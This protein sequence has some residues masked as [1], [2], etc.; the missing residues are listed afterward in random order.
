M[1]SNNTSIKHWSSEDQPRERMLAKGASV[2]SDTE[3]LTILIG[4]GSKEFSA[5]DLARKILD[6]VQG[7]WDDLG[8]LKP[9][10]LIK[11]IK[12][13]G[14]AKAITI[15]TALEIGRRRQLS[16][17]TEKT[18]LNNASIIATILQNKIGDRTE[19]A[20][21]VF[22]LRANNTIIFEEIFSTGGLTA[23]LVDIRILLRKALELRAVSI[24]IG[25]NHPS[26]SE[27]PS[28]H[29]ITLT[30]KLI[31]AGKFLDIQVL[32]HVIVTQNKFYSF[33]DDGILV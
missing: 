3:L 19:E 8:K 26:G 18:K 29:D 27:Y 24:A 2:L 16:T 20:F 28:K 9:Q 33:R 11:N 5:M 6:F 12:G 10:D 21:Y 30:N 14:P 4:S 22:Y 13:I 17:V 23:T 25:H 1:G 31:E 32:D 7:S 15:C